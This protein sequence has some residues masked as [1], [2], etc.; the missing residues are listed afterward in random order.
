MVMLCKKGSVKDIKTKEFN[1]IA[2]RKY[3][4]VR[5]LA[6]C[7]GK[8]PKLIGRSGKDYTKNFPYV[9]NALKHYVGKFDGEL[10]CFDDMGKENFQ[11]IQTRTLTQDDTTIKIAKDTI[12]VK[13]MIFDMI[14]DNEYRYRYNELINTIK[15]N[16]FLEIVLFETNLGYMWNL[17]EQG[18]W[19]GIV[20]KDRCSFYEYKKRSSNWL[21]VKRVKSK[22]IEFTSY[23]INTNGLKAVS[24]DKMITIQVGG[25][26]KSSKFLEQFEKRGGNAIV[27]VEYLEQFD[28]GKLRMPIC[29]EVKDEISSG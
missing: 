21:K 18:N 7:D 16:K 3:D 14:S 6:I 20:L 9:V 23:E 4:G 5:C 29:K 17:A 1:W 25:K 27:E 28:S 12:P 8:N 15:N 2:Q 19:E 10:C 11:K 26:E 24:K 22:D 13:F